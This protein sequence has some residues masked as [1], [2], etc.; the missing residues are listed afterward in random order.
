MR[1]ALIFVALVGA[2]VT[3]MTAGAAAAGIECLGRT[4]TIVGTEGD[5]VLIGTDGNDVIVGLGGNDLIRGLGG[6]EL[7]CAG[8][9]DDL[10]YGGAGNDRLA[11]GAGHDTSLGGTGVDDCRA[12][13]ATSCEVGP[14]APGDR[15]ASVRALQSLLKEKAL[16]LGP[17]D[18]VYGK[19]TG[20][21]AIAFHKVFER[22]RTDRF[23]RS[24]WKRLLAFEPTPPIDR[25]GESN[26]IEIDI[27]HQVLYL[28]E[29]N[30][31]AAIVP[32]ST[33][34][35]DRYYSKH[36]GMW[37]N[38]ETPR[39]DFKFRW[40][41]IGWNTDRTTGWS[42]YNYWSFSD[43]YGVHGYL[44]VPTQPA[45]HGCVRMNIWD[46]DRLMSRF[47]VGMPVHIWDA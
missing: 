35:G 45:S 39:G 8:G 14:L 23:L 30:E 2:L 10:I 4:P 33:G 41:Q 1:R 43:F 17:V 42:V 21:A 36:Q 22:E 47:K 32:V 18:G 5:D 12:E 19:S 46:S 37:R 16:Y 13:D 40:R 25:S 28:I 34:S 3:P 24:D 26:R 44:S 27:T 7:I 11:G 31:V 38:A 15:G 6:D 20:S 9:G 29:G